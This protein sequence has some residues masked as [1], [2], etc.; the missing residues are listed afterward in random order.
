MSTLRGV[1]VVEVGGF[2]AAPWA[3]MHLADLGARVIKVERPG[4][5]DA[6]R[7][8]PPVV[9]GESVAFASINRNKESVELDLKSV[10]G[11]APHF[12]NSCELRMSWSRTFVRV[13]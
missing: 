7:K 4:E 13:P 8:A 6:V 3:T 11:V 12:S 9:D 5:G 2:L 10:Q 1:T